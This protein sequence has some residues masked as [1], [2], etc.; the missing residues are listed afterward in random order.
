MEVTVAILGG[1]LFASFLYLIVFFRLNKNKKLEFI[2]WFLLSIATFNGLIFSFV[3]WA[4][5]EGRNPS[6]IFTY[7]I[8][9]LDTNLIITYIA[10]NF[11][12]AFCV[13]SGWKFISIIFKKQNLKVA[14]EIIYLRKIISISWFLFFLSVIAY[15]LYTR[16]YGGF[17]LYLEYARAIRSGVFLIEN[18]FSFLQ[19]LGGLSFFS[20]YVFFAVLMDKNKNIKVI[21]RKN[22][23]VGLV[24]S[25]F[26]SLYVLYSWMGRVGLVV[27]ISTF[28][29]GYI[30]Y[31][32]KSISRLVRKI[33]SFLLLSLLL[34]I[35]VDAILGRSSRDI[36]IIELFA[37]ECAFPLVTFY[38]VINLSEYRWFIDLI[39]APLY[40]L[41]MKIWSGVFNVETASSFNTFMIMGARKGQM[42]VYGEIPV[43]MLSFSYMQFNILGILVV[44]FLWGVTLYIIQR[45]INKIP[46]NSI[47][48]VI[49]ANLILNVPILS[50]MY[51]DPQHIIV[52][53]FNMIAAFLLLSL[54]L[55]I[56]L[57]K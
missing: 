9:Q 21:K 54:T 48:S 49:S 12:L 53:C 32:Y 47:K 10:L 55:K 29:L 14:G 39:V 23:V 56:K 31:S 33:F 2:D 3:I 11:C 4:T 18:P 28:L 13:Y 46:V 20:S 17:V 36:G 41:P 42:G 27:Y 44:G 7:Y 8:L 25:V 6:Y 30:L 24:L 37:Q 57:K 19:R 1:L 52:R 5:Y 38:S 22:I 51:G 16:A 50:V 43:D 26:F 34:L 40:L 15:W 35:S 45:L